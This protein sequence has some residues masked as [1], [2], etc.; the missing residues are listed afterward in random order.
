MESSQK[1]KIVESLLGEEIV[2]V[3]VEDKHILAFT[4]GEVYF[5]K[6]PRQDHIFCPIF[7]WTILN[8]GDF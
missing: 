2:D 6:K 5:Q 1:P 3:A 8:F 7:P 4:K